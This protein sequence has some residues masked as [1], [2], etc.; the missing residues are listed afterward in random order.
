MMDVDVGSESSNF[1]FLV[2]T[3][4]SLTAIQSFQLVS[5]L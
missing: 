3:Y 5:L 1:F 2:E 4:L